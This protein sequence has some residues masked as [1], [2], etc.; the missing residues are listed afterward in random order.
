MIYLGR[1]SKLINQSSKVFNGE[2]WVVVYIWFRGRC[3][4]YT[5][6]EPDVIESVR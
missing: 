1:I 3:Y 5:C 2:K 6:H 4:F